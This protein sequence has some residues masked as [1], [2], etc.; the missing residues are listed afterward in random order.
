MEEID[1]NFAGISATT[2]FADTSKNPMDKRLNLAAY[3][4]ALFQVLESYGMSMGRIREISL[5]IARLYVSP[6]NKVQAWLKR[7][8][9]KLAGTRIAD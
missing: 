2:K 5:D 1:A 9:A 4:L 7:L 3:F 8:P 6:K